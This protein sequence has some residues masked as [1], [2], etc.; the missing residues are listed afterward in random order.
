[1][2]CWLGSREQRLTC[3]IRRSLVSLIYANCT[4][5][6]TSIPTCWVVIQVNWNAARKYNL[7][8][9]SQAIRWLSTKWILSKSKSLFFICTVSRERPHTRCLS[10]SSNGARKLTSG[11]TAMPLCGLRT[12]AGMSSVLGRSSKFR[13]KMANM[14]ASDC[15]GFLQGSSRWDRQSTRLTDRTTK[16]SI[17]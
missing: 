15:G 7:P 13:C 1:M 2:R 8:S 14:Y 9:V 10:R 17:P 4:V 6:F 3:K 5:V 12:G 16:C 11:K